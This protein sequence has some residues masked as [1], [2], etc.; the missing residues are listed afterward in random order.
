VWGASDRLLDL[1]YGRALANAIPGARF[2]VLPN[3]GHIPQVESPDLLLKAVRSVT[4]GSGA[5]V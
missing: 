2:E 3:T 1:E 5:E 4:A